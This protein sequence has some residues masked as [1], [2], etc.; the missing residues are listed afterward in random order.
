MIM[1]N[2]IILFSIVALLNSTTCLTINAANSNKPGQAVDLGLSVKWASYNVGA[3]MPEEAG[4]YYTWGD[5]YN[6]GDDATY[7]KYLYMFDQRKDRDYSNRQVDLV[8]LTVLR[9]S[10]DVATYLWKGNWR[11]PTVFEYK[12]LIEKCQWIW[13]SQ[14][15]GYKVIGPNGNSIFIP[16]A[17]C[18]TSDGTMDDYYTLGERGVYWCS[19]YTYNDYCQEIGPDHLMFASPAPNCECQRTCATDQRERMPIRP[20]W[21][22][23]TSEQ[24]LKQSLSKIKY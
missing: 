24:S 23:V 17:G 19:T 16:A 11:I 1:K 14:K 3:T 15:L 12:E 6:T 2:N 9:P 5:I 18:Q 20:V 8:T 4:I 21:S 10:E 7:V 13:D 22:S